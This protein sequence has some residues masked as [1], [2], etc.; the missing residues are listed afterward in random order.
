VWFGKGRVVDD[1]L[2]NGT[3][4]FINKFILTNDMQEPFSYREDSGVNSATSFSA[5]VGSALR[6]SKNS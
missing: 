5:I 6:L 1:F 4:S 3:V 2:K